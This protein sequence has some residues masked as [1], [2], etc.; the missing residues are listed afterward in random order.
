MPIVGVDSIIIPG[1]GALVAPAA[2]GS[3]HGRK[4]RCTSVLI[5]KFQLDNSN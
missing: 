5:A 3:G 4:K 2:F 1:D